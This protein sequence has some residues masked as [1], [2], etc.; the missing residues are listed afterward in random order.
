MIECIHCNAD[1]NFGFDLWVLFVTG[2]IGLSEDS[3]TPCADGE[4]AG[5]NSKED[6]QNPSASSVRRPLM[7]EGQGSRARRRSDV[8][9]PA[10]GHDG[11]TLSCH[12]V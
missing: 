11:V 3:P 5:A 1:T 10:G 7:R 2:D 12:I 4:L 9:R 6:H 8:H